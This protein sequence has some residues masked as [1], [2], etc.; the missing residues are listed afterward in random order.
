MARQTNYKQEKRIKEM[1]KQKKK[2]A[3]KERKLQ[4]KKEGSEENTLGDEE[5]DL[6]P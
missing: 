3:K 2:D 4:R 6:D 5:M 1:E